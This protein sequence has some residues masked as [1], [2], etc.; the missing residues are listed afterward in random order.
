M[1]PLQCGQACLYAN[2]DEHCEASDSPANDLTHQ[3]THQWSSRATEGR[4]LQRLKVSP[5]IRLEVWPAHKDPVTAS[6]RC[7]WPT[8][9]AAPWSNG[10]HLSGR[11]SATGPQR[12]G[13]PTEADSSYQVLLHTHTLILRNTQMLTNRWIQP[14]MQMSVENCCKMATNIFLGKRYNG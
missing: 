6:L 1:A 12:A 10:G 9:T 3:L 4:L 11:A 5:L 2:T 8:I 14:D 7:S 13:W